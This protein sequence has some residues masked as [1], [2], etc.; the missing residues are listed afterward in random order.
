MTIN[1]VIDQI[2]SLIQTTIVDG[3][4]EANAVNDFRTFPDSLALEASIVF[5]GQGDLPGATGAT[6]H[7]YDVGLA[8][9][10]TIAENSS[11][12]KSNVRTADR[13]MN[14]LEDALTALFLDRDGAGYEKRPYWMRCVRPQPSTR[15]PSPIDRPRI[16]RGELYLRFI[17]L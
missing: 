1:G 17:L 3:S 5:L 15:L 9:G 10:A 2:A 12:D 4:G 7:Y 11:D 8:L 14:D 6:R 16:L 13:A